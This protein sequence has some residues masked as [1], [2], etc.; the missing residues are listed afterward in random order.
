MD[1]T[2]TLRRFRN[3]P[4]V[5][6]SALALATA[7][8]MVVLARGASANPATVS[9]TGTTLTYAA[10]AGEV[11]NLVITV[12]GPNF[13]V[14]DT[15]SVTAGTGCTSTGPMS[16]TCPTAGITSAVVTL[17]DKDDSADLSALSI[18]ASIDGGT[19]A[20]SLKGTSGGDTL[21]G[22]PGGDSL[23]GGSGIDTAD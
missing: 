8:W 12:V 4:T 14:T 9:E 16:A 5:L 13:V 3:R 17:N 19:G 11:N 10:V 7:M 22:G 23:T 20:D 15:V 18:P 6:I 1:S 2:I 21:I